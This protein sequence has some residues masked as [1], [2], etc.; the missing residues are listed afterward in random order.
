MINSISLSSQNIHK[1]D[2]LVVGGGPIGLW[3][4][5]QTKLLSQKEILV[6]EKYAEYKRADIRLNIDAS[7]FGGIPN[8]EPL[9]KLV[10]RWG[11][12]AVPIKE[13]Q[14]ELTKCAHD[15]GI[16]IIKG[17]SIDPKQLQEQFPTAKVFIGAD[18]ARSNMR[19]EIFGDQ[20]QF[21]TPLQYIA[22]V[23]YMINTPE[24]E[25]EIE[26]S[27]QKIKNA[28][29]SY[30]KQK[31]AGHLIT[32][33]IR[34][35]ENGRSQVTLRIFINEKTYREMA[36]ATFSNPYYFE[37]DLDKVPDLL[38]D[39]LIKWWGTQ[40]NQDIITDCEKTNK[41]TVIPLAS[42]AVNEV[43]KVSPK[44]GDPDEQIVNTLVGDASQAYP[45]FRAINNGLLLGTKLAKCIGDAFTAQRKAEEQNAFPDASEKLRRANL[46]ASCFKSYSRYSTIR[47]YIERIRAFVKNLFIVFSNHWIKLSHSVPWQTVK[48]REEEQKKGYQRGAD[49]W[50]KISGVKPPPL[51]PR[52][53]FKHVVK[54]MISQSAY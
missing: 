32:Q 21:N 1:P 44:N 34:P 25:D 45:F 13:M 52:K 51:P 49:I 9:Q 19:K 16:A 53:L 15:L 7:S 48:M 43:Y 29:Q 8:H 17:K 30:S 28:A 23:Q 24:T 42:Y 39:T 38:R 54:E 46:F 20:Y 47:A 22:Q 35:Q 3:T 36:G 27:V 5:I 2:V 10:Q 4:A 33:S 26:G 11:N 40:N 18:G 41:L 50:E 12:R 31:F 6:V 37:K 14:E